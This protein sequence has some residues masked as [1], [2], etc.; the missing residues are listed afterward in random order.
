MQM[1]PVIQMLMGNLQQK[2]P[3]GHQL[4]Q[5]L[6][7]N[8]GN[9]QTMLQQILKNATPEQKE[10]LFKQAKQYNVPDDVISQIKKM[11]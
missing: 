6:M 8:N 7:Q 11:K 9:P 3:Q 4:L 5:N 2:N 1:T 10:N